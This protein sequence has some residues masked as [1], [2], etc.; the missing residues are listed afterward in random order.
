MPRSFLVKNKRCTSYKVPRPNEDEPKA[1]VCTGETRNNNIYSSR[2]M[3]RTIKL[4][5]FT[6]KALLLCFKHLHECLYEFLDIYIFK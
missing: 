3:V 6:F 2:I 4:L 5:L 1:S